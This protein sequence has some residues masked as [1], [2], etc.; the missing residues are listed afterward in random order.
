MPAI[1]K[2]R[3][4]TRSDD[5]SVIRILVVAGNRENREV[6]RTLLKE[7][8]PTGFEI[9]ET[10]EIEQARTLAE[11]FLPDCILLDCALPGSLEFIRSCKKEAPLA[12]SMIVVVTCRQN[13]NRALEALKLG[14]A[15]YISENNILDGSFVKN[16]L[17]AI[18]ETR[19]KR[20]V[21]ACRENL[22]HSHRALSDFTYTVSQG[23]KLPIRRIEQCCDILKDDLKTRLGEDSAP[24]IDRLEL[25]LRRL[26]GIAKELQA[27]SRTLDASRE[28]EERRKL[29]F[30]KIVTE[31]VDDLEPIIKEHN[32]SVVIG[33]LPSALLAYPA[34][35][36]ELF[37]S[38]IANA[39]KFRAGTAPV[40]GI[41][42]EERESHFLFSVK[43]N[44]RGIAAK[45]HTMIFKAF[46][47]L[48]IHQDESGSGLGLALCSKAVDMHN[49]KIWVESEPGNGA[50]FKF[51]IAKA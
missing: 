17:K 16:I 50:T 1:Q 14:A 35:I 11:K 34:R 48:Q 40:I 21:R 45:Y 33:T 7:S 36:R 42:C 5:K 10:G 41:S 43:D 19:L 25:N 22:E 39:I 38:L 2:Q 4:L 18:E 3:D 30:G 8:C 46:E 31:V 32:A 26:T 51:T 47:S 13:E 37:Q 6:C 29:N 9:H 20:Q 15:D 49:G 12:D 28:K 44:G 27:Y 23:I 24:Y